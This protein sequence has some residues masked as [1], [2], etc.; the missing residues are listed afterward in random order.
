[1]F[2]GRNQLNDANL[3][4]IKY[5]IWNEVLH[6]KINSSRSAG[7]EGAL[8][9]LRSA[10][11]MKRNASVAVYILSGGGVR[12]FPRCHQRPQPTG[13][14]AEDKKLAMEKWDILVFYEIVS[15]SCRIMTGVYVKKYGLG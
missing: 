12:F 15:I 2:P 13:V 8:D 1:M 14:D 6:R 9:G 11:D 10:L 7:G 3:I 5:R 4:E